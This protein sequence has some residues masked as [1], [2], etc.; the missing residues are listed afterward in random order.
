MA[1]INCPECGN[2][3]SDKADK[4]IHCGFPIYMKVNMTL[5]KK[6][7]SFCGYLNEGYANNCVS[8][9]AEL[10][11]SQNKPVEKV[12]IKRIC[13]QCGEVLLKSEKYCKDCHTTIEN[14]IIQN[15][16]KLKDKWVSFFLC[17]FFGY[18]GAH[19]F[20]EGNKK[21]GL[22]YLFTAGLLGFGWFADIF[23]ILFKPRYYE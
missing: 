18:F 3:I 2:N 19:K 21:M 11:E 4:C 7:C 6:K 10:K 12:E 22:I 13:S 14:N 20:Y 5:P 23:I 17:L 15:E 8:C 1:L 9:G 16:K